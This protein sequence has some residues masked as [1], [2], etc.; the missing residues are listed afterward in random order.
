MRQEGDNVG[1]TLEEDPTEEEDTEEHEGP[2]D[3]REI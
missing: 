1:S 3:E 2:A